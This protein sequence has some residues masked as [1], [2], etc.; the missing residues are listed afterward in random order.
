MLSREGGHASLIIWSWFE[1]LIVLIWEWF[2][3]FRSSYYAF[4]R[5]LTWLIL[6]VC[7]FPVCLSLSSLFQ[8]RCVGLPWTQRILL[9]IWYALGCHHQLPG[10]IIKLMQSLFYFVHIHM[11]FVLSIGAIRVTI[12]QCLGIVWLCFDQFL[13]LFLIWLVKFLDLRLVLDD[14]L[15]ICKSQL[16]LALSTLTMSLAWFAQSCLSWFHISEAL[17]DQWAMIYLIH[18]YSIT[19]VALAE[20]SRSVVIFV[21]QWFIS[22]A[23]L[24]LARLTSMTSW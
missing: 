10:S 14:L 4:T 6:C 9:V 22:M 19:L 13:F 24:I 16:L 15:L 21:L 5:D 23:A 7:V 1:F 17:L 12:I 3:W 11:V 20:W 8:Y 18:R 2:D